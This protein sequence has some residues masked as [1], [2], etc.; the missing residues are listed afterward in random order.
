MSSG[1]DKLIKPFSHAIDGWRCGLTERNIKI[2]LTVAV[3]VLLAGILC[4]IS[5]SEWL[6]V[7]IL[8]GAVI[9]AELFN[10]A[11]EEICNT[12]TTKLKLQY[13]D[14]TA[15]RDLAAG[16]VLLI[17]VTAAVVGLIIFIPKVLRLLP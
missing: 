14:T 4:Q 11:I 17:A 1:I 9:T 2:H 12:I 10:T 8:I 7:I 16:A 5:A 3:L 6:I 13:S 15:P